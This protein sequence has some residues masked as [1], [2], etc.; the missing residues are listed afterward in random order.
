MTKKEF[1]KL[2]A[3]DKV[4]FFRDRMSL[5]DRMS[6]SSFAGGLDGKIFT[7]SHLI[8]DV[9][10]VLENHFCFAYGWLEVCKKITITEHVIDGK[11]R[12]YN[13]QTAI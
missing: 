7:V 4:Q 3:G 10:Y 6:K 5:R 11:K 8:D 13:F 9:V 12:L 2:K 1:K